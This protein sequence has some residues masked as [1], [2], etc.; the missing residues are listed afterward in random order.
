MNGFKY[1][2]LHS[3]GI[4][5]HYA[6]QGVGPL[7]VL[8][9]GF[10]ESAY[11]WRHQLPALARASYRAVALDLRGYGKTDKPQAVTAYTL[12]H[13]VGDVVGAVAALGHNE[14]I[15]VGHGCGA[16]VAWYAALMRPDV[17]HAA[18]ILGVPYEKPEH[19]LPPGQMTAVDVLNA[20]AGADRTS[21][22]VYFQQHGLAEAELET[23]LRHSVL[24]LLYTLSGDIV[25]S[26]VR[27]Q[28]WDGHFP[29]NETFTEQLVVPEELPGWLN[30]Y[31]VACYVDTLDASG[32]RGGLNGYRMLNVVPGILSPFVGVRIIQ[33]V[34]YLY[35][36]HDQIGGNTAEALT[37]LTYAVPGLRDIICLAGA[38]HWLPE[39]RPEEV[40]EALLQFLAGLKTT[41]SYF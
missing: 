33:P 31:D 37:E 18:A 19:L 25:E 28:G 22:E 32:F 8:L 15:L 1:G 7:V 21:Y 3:N 10:P 27:S 23:D 16:R 11:A 14:A 26:G 2:H 35:G 20:A 4:V 17:F 9:H 38:G 39:E 40:S 6:E 34:L 41:Y 24:G 12:S 13:L 36:E 30:E 29:E 5:M